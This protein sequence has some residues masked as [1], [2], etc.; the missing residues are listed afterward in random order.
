GVNASIYVDFFL[1]ETTTSD[2]TL[3]WACTT[4]TSCKSLTSMVSDC[5]PA[6]ENSSLLLPLSCFIL[7]TPFSLEVSRPDGPSSHVTLTPTMGVKS[8][9]PLSL[10]TTPVTT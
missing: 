1:L 2:K 10:T 9:L 4:N 8:P 3:F 6:K 5:I 7:N